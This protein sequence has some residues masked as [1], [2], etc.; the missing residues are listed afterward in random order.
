MGEARVVIYGSSDDLIEVEGDA[1]GCDEYSAE[2]ATFVLSGPLGSARVRMVYEGVWAITIAQLAEDVPLLTAAV[3]GSDY[4]VRAT[5]WGV[6]SV[7]RE[8]AEEVA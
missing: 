6:R 1:P 7:V 5:F 4:S 2:D 8:Y 3:L